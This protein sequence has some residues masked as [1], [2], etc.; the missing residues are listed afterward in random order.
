MELNE[1][2]PASSRRTLR[3]LGATNVR[4]VVADGRELPAELRDFDRALVDAPCSG[5]GVLNRRPDLRWRAEPLPE[6][7]LELLRAAAERVRP[8]GTIV[9]SVCTINADESRG[10]RRRV[11]SRRSIRPSRRSGRTFRHPR[12][13]EFLQTLPHVHG[14]AGF[15]VARLRVSLRESTRDACGGAV[16]SEPWSRAFSSGRSSSP[17]AAAARRDPNPIV[18]A[19]VVARRRDR[20]R[21]LAR[22]QGRPARRGRRARR[23]RR[24][25]AR[26]DGV[27]DARAVRA[28]RRDAA[29]R[30]RAARGGRRARRRGPARPEPGARRRSRAA[31]RGRGRG[32]ARRGRARL[33]LS[34][35]DRGVAHVGDGEAAVRDVQGRGHARRPRARAGLALGDRRGLAGGSSTCCARSRTPSRSAWARCAGTTR[36]STRAT[37]RSSRQPRRIAFGRGPLPDGSELELRSGP[38]R[39]ELEALAA[40]GVQSLL[41][42]GG[43]T[44]AAAFLEAGSRRQAARLRRAAALR[45]RAGDARRA[46]APARAL[47][48]GGAPRRRGRARPGLPQRA[49]VRRQYP[50]TVFTGIVRELGRRRRG[51]GGGRRARPRRTRAR[52]RR[53]H[54]RRRLGRDRRLL[55]HGDRGRG[56]DDPLP[57]GARDDRAHDA[58]NAS[59]ATSSVNVEPALRAGEELGGHYVQGHVDAVGRDPVGRG[60]RAR[61]SASS[62]RRPTT[63]CAT[64][65]RR[66]RSR[67]TACR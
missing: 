58:R 32:R 2:A 59:S 65:S 26:R 63:S 39:E 51:R 62:S 23:C 48:H 53:P 43:P 64:A 12:R 49:V 30:R 52:D 25:R 38:L 50:P 61:G 27:R 13:P 44:L 3:R 14:T 41:L 37:S 56:R 40:D 9:Y 35:A 8:G 19:V 33:S 66:A 24:A 46:A 15:F 11:G 42:E 29:V 21:G 20:R 28:P 55:P 45:R 54:A 16:G 47:A 6:L 18:G 4:V 31:P 1:A 67:S 60:R 36:A 57:R 17:S 34:S 10:R 22:A 5:L 7:Q